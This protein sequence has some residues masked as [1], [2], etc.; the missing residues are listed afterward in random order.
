M[1][2]EVCL[3]CGNKG[4]GF[5]KATTKA[6]CTICGAEIEWR[7]AASHYLKH[8]KRS[9]NDVVCG[10]CGAKVKASEA[11]AHIRSHFVVREDKRV[12]CGVCGREFIDVRGALVHIMKSHEWGS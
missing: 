8:T 10:I 2:G 4:D 3:I 9:G 6:K 7:D 1:P 11:R 12:F 5:Y